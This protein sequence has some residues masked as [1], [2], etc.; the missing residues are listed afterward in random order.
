MCEFF[1]VLKTD[2]SVL[3]INRMLSVMIQKDKIK[4]SRLKNESVIKNSK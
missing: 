2:A 4:E 3:K 1:F